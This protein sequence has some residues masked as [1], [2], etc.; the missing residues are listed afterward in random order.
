MSVPSAFQLQSTALGTGVTLLEASAGTGK[1]FTI[2]GIVTRLVALE[3]LPIRE[4]L[5]VTFTEAATRELSDRI[6]QSLLTALRELSIPTASDSIID[7]LKASGLDVA[8][9]RQRLELALASF[10]EASIA[11]IHGFCQ[12]ILR[13]HAFEG[14]APFNAEIITDSAELIVNL[15]YDFWHQR[16]GQLPTLLAAITGQKNLLPNDL[17]TL[18]LGLTRHPQLT[19]I[20]SR[21]QPFDLVSSEVKVAYD[22]VI[23]A[24]K[25]EGARLCNLLE[26]HKSISKNKKTGFSSG[27]V[28]ML[29]SALDRSISSG[30]VTEMALDAIDALS[31]SA[32]EE[33]INKKSAEKDPFPKDVFFSLCSRFAAAKCNWVVAL[34]E[35]WLE[36]VARELPKI[37]VVRRIMTFDDMLNLTHS[38]LQSAQGEP[39]IAAI[40]KQY[41]AA[42]IDEF[43]DS[44]P[45]QYGIF[46][47]LFSAPPHRLML[48]G[49]PKQSIYGFRG[50]DLFTYLDAR[51]DAEAASPPRIHTLNTNY[52]STSELVA[53]VNDLFRVKSDCFLQDGIEFFP[54]TAHGKIAGER[55]L[56][57]TNGAAE[58]PMVLIDATV[59]IPERNTNE[60]RR[61]IANDIAVEISRLLNGYKLGNLP[62]TAANIAIL[63]RFHHEAALIDEVLREAQ[64]PAVRQTD[65]SVFH[66]VEAEEL[67]RVLSAVLEP[68]YERAVRA[69]LAVSWMDLD[70]A[71]IAELESDSTSWAQWLDLF[72]T[73][74]DRWLTHGFSSMFRYLLITQHCHQKLVGQMGGERKL[75]NLLQLSELVQQAEQDLRLPPTGV[76]EWIR[77]QRRSERTMSDEHIQRLEK[78]DDA[79]KIVTIHKSKGLEYPIVFCPSHWAERTVTEV[80][81]HDPDNEERLTLDLCD[82]PADEHT[83]LAERERL[84]EDV[85]LFYVA[86]TR[87]QH[88]CYIYAPQRKDSSRSALGL[89]LGHDIRQACSALAQSAPTRINYRPIHEDMRLTRSSAPHRTSNLQPRNILRKVNHE[90]LTGSFSQWVTGAL[91]ETVQDHDELGVRVEIDDRTSFDTTPLSRLPR[92]AATGRALHSVLEHADFQRAETLRPLITEHFDPMNL[93]K[94]VLD[95]LTVHLTS[96]MSHPL[97][98]DG[99]DVRLEHISRKERLN[100]IEFYYPIKRIDSRTLAATTSIT[101]PRLQFN[102]VDGFLQGFM[103]LIF[104]HDDRY[105]LLDWKSNWLGPR[106][107]DYSR[108]QLDQAMSRDLYSLQSWLYALALD[109]Y[110]TQRLSDYRYDRHFGG[111]FYVF[112]RGL[113]AAH[114]EY[115]VYF[116]KPEHAFIEQLADTLLREGGTK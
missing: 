76:I 102:P 64:I 75:T 45:L 72:A 21:A 38:A 48:I 106:S 114:P 22:A 80:L 59:D 67:T 84:A 79:V 6:R 23:A 5:V 115:G 94:D 78:D 92:G 2:A 19:V 18:L 7:C 16:S 116:S 8:L 33:Q 110:L 66:S 96:M 17:A 35:L 11:T 50:A 83:T 100:E 98:A 87:A 62:V 58:P 41:R 32:I 85:R 44:D 111:L 108:Q 43:Q 49:D 40:R 60:F 15:A 51:R 47:T 107:S 13:D 69:A 12:R 68:S 10:D 29:R 71:M 93:D 30:I 26:T 36:F 28:R 90:P 37:K 61:Y 77:E 52:R 57:R 54:S 46:R 89:V 55:P 74:R 104:R 53:A 91:E 95:A 9:I 86:V 105:F 109:R 3:N 56:R 24:W 81:F 103:D 31:E 101:S 20:P 14:D 112:V 25:I 39:L 1:T 34:R 113:D 4:I 63:V 88:R 73:F 97:R 42:L 99:Y 27:R 70:A 82:P 65:A